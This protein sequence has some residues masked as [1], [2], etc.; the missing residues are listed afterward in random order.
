MAGSPTASDRDLLANL[1]WCGKESALKVLRTGLRRDTRSVEVEFP[2]GPSA[3]GWHPLLVTA[4]EG[5]PFPGWWCRYGDF[6]LTVAASEA[7]A[8]PVA[9]EDPP[10]LAGAEPTHSWWPAVGP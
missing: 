5:T 8:P 10:P 6:L 4:R 2:E 1:I 9:A 7:T 3:D